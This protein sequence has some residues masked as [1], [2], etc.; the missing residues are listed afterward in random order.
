MKT[1]TYHLTNG[2][3]KTIEYDETLP[4][5]VCGE[6]VGDASMGGTLVCPA[7]DCGKCRY[8]GIDLPIAVTKEKAIKKIREHIAWHKSERV[9]PVNKAE[10][11]DAKGK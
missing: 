8:C 9:K 1:V 11:E 3:T 5:I 7:C 4:C 2:E 10:V 6:P